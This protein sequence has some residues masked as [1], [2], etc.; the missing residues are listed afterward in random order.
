MSAE[1]PR[2][3][4]LWAFLQGI[5]FYPFGWRYR[6]A[7]PRA[8]FQRAYYVEVARRVE[9]ARFDAIVFGDQLQARGYAGRTPRHLPMPTLD[10]VT[11]L[12]TMGSVTRH[13]GLVATVSTTYNE[14]ANVADKFATLD[15]LTGGRAGWNIVTTA[16]PASAW[17][18]SQAALPEKSLRYQ[19]AEEFVAVTNQLW[20]AAAAPGAGAN[21]PITHAG[22][23]FSMQGALATPRLPQGRPV[24]VQAGQSGDGRDFAARTAEAIFCPARTLED[25]RAYRDDIRARLP[26]F[27]RQPDDVRIM[28][29]LS[30]ILAPTEDEA[31]AKSQELLELA[32]PELCIE[33]LGE[34][35]GYDLTGHDPEAPIPLADVLAG[36]ELPPADIG[37]MLEPVARSGIALVEFAKTYV[38]TPRGHHIFRGTPE[39]LADMMGQW[40]AAGACDGFTIQPAY[41]PGELEIFIDQVVPILQ[42]R[43]LLRRDYAGTTLRSH[44]GFAG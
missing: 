37:K 42:R 3:L 10:P 30:F 36:C 28:P 16:H 14:P 21:R 9:G 19:R 15:C 32:S 39:Q 11:L 25:G 43:G 35:I 18:F 40:L 38:R 26:K 23:W 29:G 8:I 34:S 22:R 17:N 2:E 12:A 44:L 7:K 4:H 24:L 27:G 31:L 41:M 1:L 6:G 33:Y 13:V 5:G 20:D